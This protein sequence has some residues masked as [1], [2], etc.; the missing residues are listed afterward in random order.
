MELY[1][2]IS[3]VRKH[4]NPSILGPY[5]VRAVGPTSATT[6]IFVLFAVPSL[7]STESIAD[8]FISR[9][10][11]LLLYGSMVEI[12]I[13]EQTVIKQTVSARNDFF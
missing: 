1:F 5:N 13:W 7:F 12:A 8:S 2:S 3:L 11:D 4:D 10:V 6:L 9:M